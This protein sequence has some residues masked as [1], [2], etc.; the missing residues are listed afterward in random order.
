M[1]PLALFLVAAAAPSI[2]YSAPEGT[3]DSELSKYAFSKWEPGATLFASSDDVNVRAAPDPA[4]PVVATLPFGAKV[5]VVAPGPGPARAGG[6]VDRWYRVKAA[7][8]DG[9]TVEGHAFGGALTPLRFEADLDGD[10]E[11]ELA[12][13]AMSW[14]FN[15]RVRVREPALPA[16]TGTATLDLK[17]SGGAYLSLRGGHGDAKLLDPRTAG[18][19]LLALASRPEACADYWEALISYRAP[20]PA[21]PGE[22]RVALKLHGITD[23]PVFQGF[24]LTFVPGGASVVETIEN[25]EEKRTSTSRY[26]LDAGQGLF[27]KLA[28]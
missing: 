6:K 26:R 1:L 19:P 21:R 17:P 4:A 8:T 13:V 15:V 14:D 7:G 27:V 20:G 12:T 24:D 18:I 28:E 22:V 2:E 23:P 10:G 16:E 9:K 3:G 25:E 11:L 5:T